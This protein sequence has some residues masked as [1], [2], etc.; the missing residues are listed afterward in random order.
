[1][2]NRPLLDGM[3]KRLA[4]VVIDLVAEDGI[5][6]VRV[7]TIAERLE[8]SLGTLYK[9]WGG[10]Q[11]M[12][13]HAWRM[14][15]ASVEYEVRHGL[16][17]VTPEHHGL[18]EIYDRIV[19]G[20]PEK[21][22]AFFELHY[23]RCKWQ[24]PELEPDGMVVPSLETFVELNLR[25][26]HFRPGPTRTLA[27]CIWWFIVGSLRSSNSDIWRRKWCVEALKRGLLTRDRYLADDPIESLEITVE[28]P[29]AVE[30][31]KAVEQPQTAEKPEDS[32]EPLLQ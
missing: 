13:E 29:Q 31:L 15:I 25:Y 24:R 17:F 9:N 11:S 8:V 22:D 2:F 12:L 32:E 5:D 10:R 28:E 3:G 1:M 21:L 14:C 20:L 18:S 16:V 4:H 27:G 19:F 26:Q 23:S 6:G 7:S 30:D